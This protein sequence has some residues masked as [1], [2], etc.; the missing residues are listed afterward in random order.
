MDAFVAWLNQQIAIK[1]LEMSPGPKDPFSLQTIASW[2]DSK[3]T[4]PFFQV[5]AQIQTAIRTRS[6]QINLHDQVDLSLNQNFMLHYLRK[7]MKE[8]EN[9]CLYYM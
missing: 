1:I 2:I 4:N 7:K 8:E 5:E 6:Q 9:F 3:L